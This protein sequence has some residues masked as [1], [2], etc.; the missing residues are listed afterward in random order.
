MMYGQNRRRTGISYL[1]FLAALTLL[2]ALEKAE[3]QTPAAADPTPVPVSA[4]V[5]WRAEMP[6]G[7]YIVDVARITSLS[8]HTYV[9]DGTM[10]VTDVTIGTQGSEL[11]RFYYLEPNLTPQAPNGVGQSTLNLA[12]DKAKEAADRVDSTDVSNQVVKNYPTT[13]HAKTIEYRLDSMASLNK[14]FKSIEDSLLRGKDG[15]FKP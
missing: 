10:L 2:P 15:R 1:L 8:M 12:K 3:A 6:G 5:F 11:A 9:V 4:R 7:D 13:T 14:L